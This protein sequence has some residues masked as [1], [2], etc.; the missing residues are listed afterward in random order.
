[1]ATKA[2]HLEAVS[3][4][5][6]DAFLAALKR[7]ISRRGKCTNIYSDNGTNFAG[8]AWKLDEEFLEAI[9]HNSIVA[10]IKYDK[11]HWHFIPPA[12]PHFGGVWEAGVK[13]V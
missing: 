6:S 4:L 9:K 10:E 2:S 5:S 8:A 3:G 13:S 7:C 11:I 12:G 1:M